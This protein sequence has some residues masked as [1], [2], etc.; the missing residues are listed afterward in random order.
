[1]L[2]AVSVPR[3]RPIEELPGM[4]EAIRRVEASLGGRGRVLVRYSGTEPKARVMVEGADEA[5]V[6]RSAEELAEQLK[7]SLSV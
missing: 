2:L 7:R 5:L 4:T 6:N 3:K 1:V